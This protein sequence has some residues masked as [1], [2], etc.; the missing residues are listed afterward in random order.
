M[1]PFCYIG[2]RR[3]EHALEQFEYNDEVEIEWKSF[4]LNPHMKTDP[5]A[6]IN[7]YLARVKGWSLKEAQSMNE[8]VTKMAKAEGLEYHMDQAVVANSFDAHRLVQYA[9]SEDKDDE[10]EEALFK[11]YFTEG[12]NIADHNTLIDIADSAGLDSEGV[13]KMLQSEDYSQQVKDEVNEGL[14]LGLRGVPFFVIDRSHAVVGAQS[15]EQLLN[16]LEKAKK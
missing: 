11:A 2:K 10:I 5:D 7:E 3:L 15:S 12:K 1:C 13:K 9:K 6:N 14:E 8:R 4:Q 16:I